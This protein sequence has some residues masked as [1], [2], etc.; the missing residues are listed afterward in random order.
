M[1]AMACIDKQM[2]IQRDKKKKLMNKQNR[3]GQKPV[4]TRDKEHSD[5]DLAVSSTHNDLDERIWH[6]EE[7]TCAIL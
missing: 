7:N 4:L 1:F 2:E 3:D 5:E 6:T